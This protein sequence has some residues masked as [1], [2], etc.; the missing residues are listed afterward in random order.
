MAL[1]VGAIIDIISI[2]LTA[3]SIGQTAIQGAQE[4]TVSGTYRYRMRVGQ[5]VNTGDADGWAPEVTY[6]D[7]NWG[8][9][10]RSKWETHWVDDGGLHDEQFGEN[11]QQIRIADVNAGGNAICAAWFEFYDAD[12]S[13]PVVV[14][15]GNILRCGGYWSPTDSYL[16]YEDN[17]PTPELDCVW[18]NRGYNGCHEQSNGNTVFGFRLDNYYPYWL[19]VRSYE[20]NVDEICNNLTPYHSGDCKRDLDVSQNVFTE[21]AKEVITT[22]RDIA[23]TYCEHDRSRGRS[24][25]SMNERLF[26]DMRTRELRPL[27][28][29]SPVEGCYNHNPPQANARIASTSSGKD[30]E[31]VAAPVSIDAKH[32]AAKRSIE[33]RYSVSVAH[34]DCLPASDER[35]LHLNSTHYFGPASG[36]VDTQY[37]IVTGGIYTITQNGTA[38]IVPECSLD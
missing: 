15:G 12:N 37:S 13:P 34:G 9:L 18:L 6:Y 5:N 29:D 16:Y 36:G 35:N 4:S 33:Q 24:I 1:V 26:C 17:S 32:A 14:L 3:A 20:S 27:C 28:E 10:A 31:L 7:G 8:Q 2:G 21:L 22:N 38:V 23:R 30:D 25:L 19:G 11:T